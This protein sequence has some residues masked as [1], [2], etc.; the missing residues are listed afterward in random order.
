MPDEKIIYTRLL[1]ADEVE[2]V[3]DGLPVLLEE[4]AGDCILVAEYGWGCN[5][6]NDLQYVPMQVGIGWLDNF[7]A[8]SKEQKIY[9]PAES[10]LSITTPDGSLTI[11]FCHESDIHLSGKN[12]ELVKK[13]TESD[14]IRPL[15]K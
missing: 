1:S 10:D 7:L 4:L 8:E 2:A 6:H 11:L 12:A 15:L 9:L 13:A 3:L 5:I 14:L